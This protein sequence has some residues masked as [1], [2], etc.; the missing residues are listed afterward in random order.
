[1]PRVSA[2]EPKS[3]QGRMSRDVAWPFLSACKFRIT[4]PHNPV[5]QPPT[6]SRSWLWALFEQWPEL[7][8]PSFSLPFSPGLYSESLRGSRQDCVLHNCNNPAGNRRHKPVSL[9][10]NQFCPVAAQL[11]SLDEGMVERQGRS[12][13]TASPPPRTRTLDYSSVDGYI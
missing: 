9:L 2:R 13:S 6:V 7:T 11:I 3:A 1:M 10:A 4:P 8:T 5:I 12:Y